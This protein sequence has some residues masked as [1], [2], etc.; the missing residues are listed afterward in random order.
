MVDLGVVVPLIQEAVVPLIQEAAVV[1]LAEAVG[2]NFEAEE[3]V[4]EEA[5]VAAGN[6]GGKIST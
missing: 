1:G 3:A 2:L 4:L 5:L 6:R